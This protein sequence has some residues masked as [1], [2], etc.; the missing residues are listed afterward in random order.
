MKIIFSLLAIA[1]GI[2]SQAQAQVEPMMYAPT[3]Y[4][5][6]PEKSIN[7]VYPNSASEMAVRLKNVKAL[8]IDIPL[9]KR[10]FPFMK[11]WSTDKI[12][13]WFEKMGGLVSQA[14]AKQEVV[15]TKIE[16][17][18]ELVKVYRPP[19]YGRAVVVE[20]QEGN[21]KG[22]F[23]I[24]MSGVA[25]GKIPSH[26]P[27]GNG[28]GTL[29]EVIR[30]DHVENAERAAIAHSLRSNQLTSSD[31]SSAAKL[32]LGGTVAG[33]GVMYAG[34]DVRHQDGSTSPAGIYIRQAHKRMNYDEDVRAAWLPSE[35]KE[36]MLRQV[37]KYGFYT[38]WESN[39][40]G[41]VKNNKVYVFDFGHW[42]AW[43]GHVSE[44][45]IWVDPNLAVNFN[46]WGWDPK[47]GPSR[48]K[49]QWR[50]SKLDRPWN[51]AHD[52][53]KTVHDTLGQVYFTQ[54]Y[55]KMM[56]PLLKKLHVGVPSDYSRSCRSIFGY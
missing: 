23:E 31:P 10:D 21:F 34:Y 46:D 26:R 12:F 7:D 24:K 3:E 56:G 45:N 32:S 42:I 2:F 13:S 41:L 49:D 43:Q 11:N 44:A 33:Y 36:D 51:W 25:E 55:D 27:H 22:A 29:G 1:L 4:A 35:V 19:G 37:S 6:I 9:V 39:L 28:L 5:V 15:N 17:T 40:Q 53:A 47:D 52:T 54:H 48:E 50:T 8:K 18:G 30:E 14:Q 20:F 38:G 16:T